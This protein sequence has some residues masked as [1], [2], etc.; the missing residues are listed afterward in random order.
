MA[1]IARPRGKV[2][3]AKPVE[4]VWD[5]FR[6]G[7]N[8]LLQDVEL[9]DEEYRRGDNLI[10]KG[11][12]I[13]TTRPGTANYYQAGGSRVRSLKSYYMKSG[14]KELL[15]LTDSGYLTKKN[16]ASYTIIPGGSYN[17]GTNVTMSQIYDKVYISSISK[18]LRRYDGTTLT[19][20][21]GI[22]RPS[23]VSATKNSGTSG[24]WTYSWRV[25]AESDV[26]E[27]LASTGVTVT[28]L[29]EEL[30][31]TKYVTIS[32]ATVPNAT[33]YVI[34]GRDS[35]N[36]TFLTRVQN[37][38]TSWVDDGSSIPSAFVFPAE[39]DFTAG[40][41][42]KYMV[43]FRDKLVIGN[44]ENNPSRVMFS[45]GGPNVDKF[46][47]SKGGGYI[48]ISKDD[49]EV[50]TGLAEFENKVVVFK[51]R[52]IYQMT[53]TYNS[54]LGIV[55]PAITK[56]SGSI[57]C[58]S[59]ETIKAVENDI[60]FVGRRA[61]G[62]I[63]LNALGYE[64]NFTT[65]LRTSEISNRIRPDLEAVN[66]ARLTEMWGYFYAQKYW[67]FY[68]VGSTGMYCFAYDRERLA[69]LGPQYFPNS[70][71]CGEVFYDDN[72]SEHFLYGDGDDGFVTEISSGYSNDKGTGFT[73]Q[74]ETKKEALKDPFVLKNLMSCLFHFRN[75]TGNLSVNIL[76][77]TK[78][79]ETTTTKSFTVGSQSV[80]AGW[81]SFL[82]GAKGYGRTQQASMSSSNL[83]DVIKYIQVNKTSV[84]TVSVR[85]SGTGSS[86][87][88]VAMK[89]VLTKLSPLSIPAS[90]RV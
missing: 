41:K 90:W 48:D 79:G 25:S 68:P 81:G 26:G 82:F 35:G 40:P 36:E 54:S 23:S 14:T 39:A 4:V 34:Y 7:V 88:I 60:F 28:G 8:K 89:L 55:E 66:Q 20:Y 62:A 43:G 53:L 49:G 13:I 1:T 61:G 27:T 75:I 69:W 31:T 78:S 24:I 38:Q 9:S 19:S 83:V 65:V 47:W 33:G 50:I 42:A 80:L 45:G 30:E 11:A 5:S 76:V 70:P 58:L 29:P 74:L 12:G 64:P 57:G 85:I 87:D 63:S 52:S 16:S 3:L 6:R 21:V 67:L 59:H 71:S 15:A 56:I 17:S 10:L 37:T 72:G 46:H 86:V 51:E 32:W 44:L 22:N 84:R 77:E 18:E 73:W 2:Q